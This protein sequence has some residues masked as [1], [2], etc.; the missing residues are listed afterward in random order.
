KT[1]YVEFAAVLLVDKAAE[2]SRHFQ[3]TLGIDP[4]RVV[5]PKHKV[6]RLATLHAG[7][8][9]GAPGLS[10]G[11]ADSGKVAHDRF[12]YEVGPTSDHFRPP[13]PDTTPHQ[14]CC[15]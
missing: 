11:V 3:P 2:L 15:Q 13:G 4:G 6:D 9:R 7:C 5:S 8:P 1:C 12:C 14:F 10:W